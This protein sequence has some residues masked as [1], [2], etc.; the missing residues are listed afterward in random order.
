M[1]KHDDRRKAEEKAIEKL[2]KKTNTAKVVT[3][4]KRAT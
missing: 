4:K 2:A 3:L 1:S